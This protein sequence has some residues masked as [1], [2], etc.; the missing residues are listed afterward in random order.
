MNIRI[1]HLGDNLK[2][3]MKKQNNSVCNLIHKKMSFKRW[4]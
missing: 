4:E 1:H 2:R 3:L